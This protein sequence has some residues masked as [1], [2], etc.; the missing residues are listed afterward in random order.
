METGST[1]SNQTQGLSRAALSLWDLATREWKDWRRILATLLIRIPEALKFMP[2]LKHCAVLM[3]LTGLCC[4]QTTKQISPEGVPAKPEEKTTG[5]KDTDTYKTLGMDN[6]RF[7]NGLNPAAKI[8][9]LAG[10][11]D[12][13]IFWTLMICAARSATVTKPD[14]EFITV[15]DECVRR[16]GEDDTGFKGDVRT[17]DVVPAL[18]KFYSEP[19]NLLI[20][21]PFAMEIIA[22]RFNGVSEAKIQERTENDRRMAVQSNR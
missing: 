16:M 19:A 1:R 7:W 12:G 3:L 17:R 15:D 8:G 6:G 10:F 14:A 4:A 11:V 21:L 22:M 20:P 5:A 9:F 2:T 18:D 13:R